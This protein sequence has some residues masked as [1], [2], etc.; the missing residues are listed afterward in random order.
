MSAA[1]QEI[2]VSTENG[3]GP[4]RIFGNEILF[5]YHEDEA[6]SVALVGD[7]N[8]WD[9][10]ANMLSKNVSGLWTIMIPCLDRGRYS[11]KFLVDGVRWV[12]DP[13][14]GLKEIDGYGGFN[15]LLQIL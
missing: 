2:H 6:R 14:N 13:S 7:L 15:S 3:F 1:V 9:I 10:T 4:P 5:T 8:R 12:E 11:Y